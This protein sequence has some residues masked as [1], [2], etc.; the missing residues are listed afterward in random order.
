MGQVIRLADRTPHPRPFR[1]AALR[2]LQWRAARYLPI[3]IAATPQERVNSLAA[4]GYWW[5]VQDVA[6]YVPFAFIVGF[7]LACL[8]V[9]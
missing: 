2:F 8:V 9:S 1:A 5:G 3:A 6:L 7:C 4:R